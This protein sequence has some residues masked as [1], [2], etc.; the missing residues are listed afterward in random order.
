[1]RQQ[2]GSL[3]N[4]DLG[5]IEG[6]RAELSGRLQKRYGIAKDEAARQIDAWLNTIH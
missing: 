5:V 6:K 4:D 2:W 1:V 3:T